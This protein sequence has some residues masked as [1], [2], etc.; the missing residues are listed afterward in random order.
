[1]R[2]G[3]KTS[4]KIWRFEEFC[5]GSKNDNIDSEFYRQSHVDPFTRALNTK[6]EREENRMP[7]LGVP[8]SRFN[9]TVENV[10]RT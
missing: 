1:M 6:H 8:V 4:S 5:D 2:I 3:R 9:A 7:Q 10:A